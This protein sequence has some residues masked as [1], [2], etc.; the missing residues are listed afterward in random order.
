MTQLLG[1]S[2]EVRRRCGRSGFSWRR[3]CM[4]C[5]DARSGVNL[6]HCINFWYTTSKHP[7]HY[8]HCLRWPDCSGIHTRSAL[9]SS[10]VQ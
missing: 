4:K 3:G 5:T 7:R 1:P 9:S 8:A 10:H 6:M 2:C